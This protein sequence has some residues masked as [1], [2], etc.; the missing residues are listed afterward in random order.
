MNIDDLTEINE[1]QLTAQHGKYRAVLLI[2]SGLY[3]IGKDTDLKTANRLCDVQPEGSLV[4][5][6]SDLGLP[7]RS[8]LGQ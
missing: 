5:I 4:Q 8:T 7:K 3:Q 2:D 1:S 6:Y